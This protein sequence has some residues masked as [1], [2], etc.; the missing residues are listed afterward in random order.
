MS[1]EMLSG[2]D[3]ARALVK[4]GHSGQIFSFSGQTETAQAAA[5]E[6]GVSVSRI[7]KS[8]VFSVD[9][10]PVL[11]LLQ[12]D[13][14]ADFSAI[15][16][17]LGAKKV[18]LAFPEQVVKWTGYPVGAVPPLGHSNPL[19]IIIDNAIEQE[20]SI[21]PAAGEKNNAFET[22]LDELVNMTGGSIRKVSVPEGD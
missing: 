16:R 7:I 13:R 22:S 20:V 8:M 17:I 18:R 21:Y 19:K 4:A 10:T 14:K 6:L 5:D 1:P 11:V 15:A 9:R 12:G 3:V 2:E